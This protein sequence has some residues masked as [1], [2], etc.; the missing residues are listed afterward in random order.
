[1]PNGRTLASLAASGL[2]VLTA[3]AVLA[4]QERDFHVTDRIVAVVGARP[5]L[6]SRLQE[7]VNIRKAQG[8][9][10]PKDSAELVATLREILETLV[11]EELMVQAAQRDTS[12]TLLQTDVQEAVETAVKNVRA[13]FTSDVDFNRGLREAGWNTLD[14]YRQWVA[15]QKRKETL[16]KQFVAKLRQKGIIKPLPATDPEGRAYYQKNKS[17]LPKRPATVSFKQIVAQPEPDASAVAESKRRADSVVTLLR[18][19]GDFTTLAKRHT[20]DESTRELGG[21]LGWVRRGGGLA[22]QFEAVAFVLRPGQIS[23]PVRTSFG[24]HIIQVERIDAAEIQVRHILFMPAMTDENRARAEDRAE[25]IVKALRAGAPFDSLARLYHDPSEDPIADGMTR[26]GLPAEYAKAIEGAKPGDVI[27]PFGVP[28]PQGGTKFVVVQY[29]EDRAAG[30][31][32]YEE[33]RDQIKSS[34]GEK[35]AMD[36]YLNELKK[37]TYVDIRL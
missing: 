20:D 22:R 7:E 25:E 13:Q 3:P 14:E 30:D 31:I 19:G 12:I 8:I 28:S 4:A 24:W 33:V 2:L 29:I 15:D 34:L 27:G 5:I 18:K 21:E 1:M 17:L 37:R 6:L 23:D 35:N 11:N 26:E 32:T 9:A 16:S 36:L 10:V